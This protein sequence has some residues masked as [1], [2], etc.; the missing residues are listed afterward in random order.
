MTTYEG[1]SDL[2]H[3]VAKGSGMRCELG[4]PMVE[5]VA[6]LTWQLN[7][8]AVR[9]AGGLLPAPLQRSYGELSETERAGMRSGVERVL[10][11]LV[12]LGVVEQ[13]G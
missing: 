2:A 1:V 4:R 6:A 8:E 10:T 9:A 7:Q 12:L 13:P 3:L 11:A 5:A